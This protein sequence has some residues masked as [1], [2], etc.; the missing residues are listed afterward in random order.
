MEKRFVRN[1]LCLD[2]GH[3]GVFSPEE[4]RAML[5]EAA[6]ASSSLE[7]IED[8]EEVDAIIRGER[9]EGYIIFGDGLSLESAKK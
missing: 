2:D 5:E 7:L 8:P 6:K 3:S 9:G 4:M 1:V